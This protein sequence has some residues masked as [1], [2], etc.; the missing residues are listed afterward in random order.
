MAFASNS[1]RSCNSRFDGYLVA[2]VHPV[3]LMAVAEAC[4]LAACLLLATFLPG[5]TYWAQLFPGLMLARL[6]LDMSFP[7]AIWLWVTQ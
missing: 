1:C 2:R 4:V 3:M 5:Q 7:A 6:G